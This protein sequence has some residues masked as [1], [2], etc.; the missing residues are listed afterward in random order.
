MQD[1]LFVFGTLLSGYDHPMSRLLSQQA[2]L[3]GAARCRGRLYLVKH[4]P[5]MV[6]SDDPAE[7]V[8][9]ELYRM[10]EPEELLRS[11]DRY[12]ACGEGSAEP[13]EF[14]RR[15]CAVTLEDETASEAWSY[16]FN[17][18]VTGLPRIMSGRFLE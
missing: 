11:L 7:Q 4:Y 8:F 12:E 14:V 13:T 17:W 2:D 9:G 15:L 6:A 3:V 5:G 1:R 10:R 16:F 18:P